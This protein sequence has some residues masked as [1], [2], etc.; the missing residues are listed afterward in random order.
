[1]SMRG[2][3]EIEMRDVLLYHV[4]AAGGQRAFARLHGVNHAFVSRVLAGHQPVG[5]KLAAVL[6]Y[7]LS[8]GRV[9]FLPLDEDPVCPS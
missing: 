9:Y 4:R 2:L 6:G 8:R 5:K 7:R 1:M 3:T